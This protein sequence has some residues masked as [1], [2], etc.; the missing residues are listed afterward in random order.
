MRPAL[1]AAV[2]GVLMIGHTARAFAQ[3]GADNPLRNCKV[4]NMHSLGFQGN[5]PKNEADRIFKVG[6]VIEC[7]STR[8]FAEDIR[9]TPKLIIASG[10]L[11]LTQDGLRINAERMEMDRD[12]HLGVFHNAYGTARLTDQPKDKNLFGTME[13]EIAFRAERIERLGPRAYKLTNGSFTTCVQPNP[14]WAMRGTSGT[15]ILGEHATMRNVGF[16]VKGIPLLYIPYL[17]YPLKEEDRSTGFLIPTYSYSQLKGHGVSSA[18]FWAINRSQDAT[19]YYDA[20]SQG[21][22]GFGADYRYAAAP[23]SRGN[24]NV[25]ALYENERIAP[26]GTLERAAHREYDI[27]GSVNQALPGGFRL[28]GEAIYFTDVVT[29]QLYQQNVFDLTRSQRILNFS[30]IGN[31]RARNKEFAR[32]EATVR[33]QDFFTDLSSASRLGRT[34][35]VNLWLSGGELFKKNSRIYYGGFAEV[36]HIDSRPNLNDPAANRTLWRFDGKST[37]RATPTRSEWMSVT[38][39]ASVRMTR[40]LESLDPLSLMPVP[41]PLTRNLVEL[42]A[43]MV[44]PR[45]ARVFQTPSNGFAERFKHQIEPRVAVHWLSPFEKAAQVLVTDPGIDSL[46]GGTATV[47]YSLSNILLARVRKSGGIRRVF[48]IDVGQTYYSNAQA[49]AIDPQYATQNAT[50]FTPVQVTAELSPTDDINGRFQMSYNTTARAVQAYSAQTNLRLK[51]LDLRGQWSK[52]FALPGVS[53]FASHFLGATGQL[54]LKEGR[55]MGSY[56][57]NWDVVRN[58]LLQQRVMASVN[59]QC[60][61]ITVDYQIINVGHIGLSTAATD[62]R[63]GVSFTLAGI[64]SFSNPLGSFRQ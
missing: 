12:T 23:G 20:Y 5:D 2:A 59:A 10:N 63:F 31:I 60:C 24:L 18:F 16:F 61:G 45:V 36:A 22:Q 46:V 4:A 25:H 34:P 11:L 55:Y 38:T 28:I 52:S 53:P 50:T 33:Q 51:H 64:G 56:G 43:D 40:W 58:T 26:G 32:L 54:S 9:I 3:E 27:R 7:D 47:T 15:I 39:F 44:G 14:R 29:Q 49:G 19:L 13:P 57:F 41:V 42:Q 17:Y 8:L 62:R 35:Q 6:V 30:V 48:S 21:V 37:L 1:I